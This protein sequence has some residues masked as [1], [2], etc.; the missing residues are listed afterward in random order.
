MGQQ[1]TGRKATPLKMG[2]PVGRDRKARF[3]RIRNGTEDGTE[4]G[5][6]ST[7]QEEKAS[8]PKN[9][10]TANGTENDS[11][12]DGT[13]DGTRQKGPFSIPGKSRGHG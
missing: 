13:A 4:N 2:Q 8:P 9:G 12:E 1:Q 7:S 11:V 5:T 6:E 3:T 10:T